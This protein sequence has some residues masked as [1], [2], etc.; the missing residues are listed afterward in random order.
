MTQLAMTALYDILKTSGKFFVWKLLMKRVTKT[1]QSMY[2]VMRLIMKNK[3]Q[4]SI[5]FYWWKTYN[6]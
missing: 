4:F 3:M 5:V 2:A 6:M 1:G